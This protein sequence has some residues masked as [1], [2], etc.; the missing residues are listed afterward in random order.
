MHELARTVIL[1]VN[2]SSTNNKK[3]TLSTKKGCFICKLL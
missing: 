3:S 2:K 1:R